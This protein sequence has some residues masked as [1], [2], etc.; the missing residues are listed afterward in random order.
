MKQYLV[1]VYQPDGDPPPDLD[2]TAVMREVGAW[3]QELKDAGAWL[4]TARLHP[5]GTATVIQAGK[6]EP[7]YTDGPYVEG[8]EH[9]GGFTAI[10]VDDLDAALAWAGKIHNITGLP[11]EVRPMFEG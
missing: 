7:L 4:F 10:Q 11:I 2:L 9:L 8:K 3:E 6:G 5:A 1:S